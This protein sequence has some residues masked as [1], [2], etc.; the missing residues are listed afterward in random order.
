VGKGDRTSEFNLGMARFPGWRSIACTTWHKWAPVQRYGETFYHFDG[1]RK[2]KEKF[3]PFGGPYL[4]APG[5]SA[6]RAPC[7]M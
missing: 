5:R 1:L 4:A 2:Y 7:S 6:S 3:L